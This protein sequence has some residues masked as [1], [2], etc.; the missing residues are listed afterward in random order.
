ML[1]AYV[2]YGCLIASLFLLLFLQWA[3][4]HSVGAFRQRYGVIA[5]Q[6]LNLCRVA[7]LSIQKIDRPEAE[8]AVLYKAIFKRHTLYTSM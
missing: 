1:E 7:I 2:R 4:V 8:N 5:Y 3:T 6:I